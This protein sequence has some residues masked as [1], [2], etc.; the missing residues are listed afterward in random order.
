MQRTTRLSVAVFL[1][2]ILALIA[3]GVWASPKF[4]GTVPAVP[5]IGGGKCSDTTRT[6]DMGTAL[7]TPLEA[8]CN[9]EVVKIDKPAEVYAPAPAGLAFDGDTFKVTVDPA[10]VLVEEVFAYPPD[11][12]AKNV[13]IYK[14][15][16]AANPPVWVE[17]PGAVVASGKISVKGVSGI[18]TVLGNP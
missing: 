2:V 1:V 16:E 9:I 18:Y 8:V 3:T 13:K 17:V 14:L 4:Q 6:V 15:N 10:T 7:F 11:F 12:A 5:A